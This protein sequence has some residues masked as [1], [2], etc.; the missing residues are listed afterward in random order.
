[1]ENG[2]SV[3]HPAAAET[4]RRGYSEKV[5]SWSLGVLAYMLLSGR[6]P[7]PGSN[8]SAVMER[9]KVGKFS[10]ASDAWS[11]VS[12]VA[13]SFVRA[14]LVYNPDKRLSPEEALGHP[15]LEAARE[16]SLQTPLPVD[17]LPSLRRFALL[18]GWKRAAMEAVA[19]RMPDDE[20][21]AH[22][23]AAF[24]RL[25]IHN[26]GYVCY[27]D[28]EKALGGVGVAREE[29]T[30]LFLASALGHEDGIHWS[31]F[32][33]AVLPRSFLTRERLR[34][35]FDALD[36]RNEGV[37]THAAFTQAL[38]DDATEVNIE[39]LFA[40][41]G[42]RVDFEAFFGEFMRDT[43]QLGSG[44]G[45]G[46]DGGGGGTPEGAQPAGA[47]A[48]PPLA[49]PSTGQPPLSLRSPADVPSG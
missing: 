48:L 17:V 25:D 15:W 31:N 44:G 13:K 45:G 10:L 34:Q 24:Q 18:G 38:A 49:L 16:G 21:I 12:D 7:F 29:A 3:W 37:L 8:D 26:N 46:G 19:F 2:N 42:P 4:A 5:D 40:N 9:V 39:G 23:R 30:T 28:F 36:V 14:L 20:Q 47:G 22:L 43:P 6:P 32:L 33:A 41:L 27:G 11:E 1:M 35:A